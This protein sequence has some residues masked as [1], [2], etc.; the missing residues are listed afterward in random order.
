[1][2]EY[3]KKEYVEKVLEEMY[4]EIWLTDIP[5]PTVPEYVEHHEQIQGLLRFVREKRE[6]L[7]D[8]NTYVFE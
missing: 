1:M 7:D 4:E 5:S 8:K 3:V 2:T 6:E